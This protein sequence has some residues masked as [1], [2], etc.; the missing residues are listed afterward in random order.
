MA[1][2]LVGVASGTV[3]TVIFGHRFNLGLSDVNAVSVDTW[4][5][6]P[7]L[8]LLFTHLKIRSDRM[9]IHKKPT[10]ITLSLTAHLIRNTTQTKKD[11]SMSGR[12]KTSESIWEGMP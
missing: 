9:P 10:N 12:C 11:D 4:R 5:S 7:P 3:S 1:H 8:T 2:L 6:H